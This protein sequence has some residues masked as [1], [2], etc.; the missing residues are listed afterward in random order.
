MEEKSL[1]TAGAKHQNAVVA[2]LNRDNVKDR[3]REILGAKSA[4]F[5]SSV[6]A[7]VSAN[8]NLKKATPESVYMAAMMAAVVDLPINPNLGFAY[9]I[10]YNTT[11]R[12][13][14]GNERTVQ[15][16][17]FQM[18]YKGFIQ[19]AQR[20]GQYK[21]ISAAPIYDGQLKSQDPLK[22]FEFDWEAK[23]N[24][25]I[26]GYAAYFALT[27]GFEKIWFMSVEQLTAHAKQYSKTFNK[28]NSRWKTDF[29]GMAM[30][31][32]LKL[33]ISKYG[34]LSVD[35]QMQKAIVADQAIIHNAETMEVEYTDASHVE[36]PESSSQENEVPEPSAKDVASARYLQ[37]ILAADTREKLDN[38]RKDLKK[39]KEHQQAYLDQDVKIELEEQAA[40]NMEGGQDQ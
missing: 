22:G 39:F 5:I 4:A 24:D 19:L 36:I 16:A 17:Q 20:S 25:T 31:T 33:L 38:L 23:K 37:L 13:K 21:T 35:T 9:I 26:I 7:T 27:N 18:G 10:P 11:I 1:T 30:K 2:F 34:P 29:P 28:S 14:E 6:L 3:F 32:V 8:D 15:V 12:D 40:K